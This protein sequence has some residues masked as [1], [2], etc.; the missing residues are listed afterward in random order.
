MNGPTLDISYRRSQGAA[1]QYLS[2]CVWFISMSVIFPKFTHSGA[3]TQYFLLRLNNIPPYGWTTLCHPFIYR[4]TIGCFHLRLLCIM[5]RIGTQTGKD[6]P[7]PLF[8]FPLGRWVPGSG[9]AGYMV[10]K[11]TISLQSFTLL[12]E[13][14]PTPLDR[15]S[16]GHV[17]R[18]A[19]A[20]ELPLPLL[21]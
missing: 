20:H 9:I 13:A 2:L 14:H 17:A 16:V 8:S 3:C 1:I 21:Q 10:R 6:L 11:P 18:G 5:L 15:S 19:Q 12:A 7:V 4:R